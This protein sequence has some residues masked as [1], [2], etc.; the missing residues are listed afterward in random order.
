MPPGQAL[1]GARGRIDPGRRGTVGCQAWRARLEE[2]AAALAPILLIGGLSLAGGGFA[3][4][5]R[6][7]AGLLAWLLVAGML[8]LGAGGRSR[9]ARP[10]RLAAGLTAA[11][12][13]LCAVSAAWSGSVE[14]S[15][16]EAD[17]VLAYLGFFVAAFLLARTAAARRRLGEGIALAVIGVAVLALA[18]R[19]L[20]DV[21]SVSESAET[22]ARLSWPLGYWN[23][24]G[25][26][27]G[28][29]A[30]MALWLS[31]G[32]RA[33]PLRAL[34]AAALPAVLLALY[35][36]YSRGGLLALAISCGVLV[37]L[38]RDRLW[39]LAT[40]ATGALACTP[41]LLA[42]QARESLAQD[43]EDAH[44]A[45]QGATVALILLAGCLAAGAL[46][47]GLRR[48]ER[49]GGPLTGRA[50]DASRD[51]RLL[52]GAALAAA[53]LALAGLVA[54]GGRAK[55]EFTR[56]D[57]RALGSPEAF[58]TLSGSGRDEFWRVGVEAFRE[59][60]LLG[61]G[62]G[63][64]RFS[65]HLLRDNDADNLD[66]HSLYLQAFAELGVVGGAL[67]LA[68]VGTLL[69]IGFAAWRGARGA[70]RDL[71]AALLGAALAFA[72]CAAID[73]F[74]LIAALGAVFFVAS[75]VLGAARCAQLAE[76][77]DG[78]AAPR[79]R[80]VLGALALVGAWLAA[81][82]LV[83]PLLAQREIDASNAAAAEGNL[84]SA[85]NHAENARAIEPWATSPYR[86]LGLLAEREGD[87]GAA[88][89]W[90]N[91]AID[92]EG[93]SW[94]LYYIR[95]R[96]NHRA[97]DDVAAAADLAEAK[98]LNPNERCLYE[99]YEGCG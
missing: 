94:L 45:G 46:F 85:V 14:L 68:L 59:E 42:V 21:V 37:A 5:D 2:S 49:R 40:L 83:A 64:Y 38:S 7:L 9:P 99:G 23:G 22:G 34:A 26:L 96:V 74:W 81:L 76:A 48:L 54:V 79:R 82:A 90:L 65:W 43:L 84:V 67:V 86:Q 8:V 58:T 56:P 57:V 73:W 53:V 98:R 16:I 27:F 63:A 87:Y 61:Q 10:F 97:G 11:L 60:P 6:H 20:P 52:R 62:A 91:K 24:D 70:A 95:A 25:V 93:R 30:G 44:V 66:A 19:L 71:H 92:R 75:A 1:K 47:V 32:A 28:I 18:S 3:L 77:G 36:T 51:P 35:F 12:G 13:A 69:G 29:A 50:L 4:T 55:D 88:L 89:E 17:R 15:V 80:P 72:V 31:R 39:H 78:A 41:A 33:E